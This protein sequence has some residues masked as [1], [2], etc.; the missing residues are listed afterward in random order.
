MSIDNLLS[1]SPDQAS[2]DLANQD[3]QDNQSNQNQI[4]DEEKDALLFIQKQIELEDQNIR[5]LKTR[6]WRR[7]DLY[8]NNIV[9]LFWDSGVGDWRIPDWDNLDSSN[10]EIAPRTIAIYRAHA[11]TVIAALSVQTPKVF[12]FPDD[13]DNPDDIE[14]AD[15]CNVIASVIEK[16]NNGPMLAMKILQILF[17]QG[18][19]FCYNYVKKDMAYGYHHSPIFADVDVPSFN[20]TCPI[21]GYDF[22]EFPQEITDPQQCFECSNIVTPVNEQ[23][24]YKITLQT[25]NEKLPKH[26]VLLDVSGPL[27]TKVSFYAKSQKQCGYLTFKFDENVAFLRDTFGQPLPD[28]TPSLLAPNDIRPNVQDS[29]Y[30]DYVRFS[31]DYFGS[32]PMNTAVVKC[33][34]LMPWMFESLDDSKRDTINLLKNRFKEGAYLIF[35]NDQLAEYCDE[36]LQ[37]HWTISENPLSNFVHGEPLGTNLAMAQDIRA[38]ACEL[39]LQIMEHSITETFVDATTIDRDKYEQTQASPGFMTPVK[40][41]AGENLSSSFFETRAANLTDEVNAVVTGTDQDAQ[42]TTGSLPSVYGGD[43]NPGGLTPV[44]ATQYSTSRTQALKRLGIVWQILCNFWCEIMK[45]SVSE[46]IDNMID[47][48]KMVTKEG[49]NFKNVLIKKSSL[50]GKI[51]SVETDSSDHLPMSWEDK[52]EVIVSLLQMKDPT[53]MQ[54][55][56]HPENAEL[57]KEIIALPEMYIPGDLDRTR[58]YREAIILMSSEPIGTADPIT[59]DMNYE[60]SLQT[61]ATDD[62]QVHMLICKEILQSPRGWELKQQEIQARKPSGFTNLMLHYHLHEQNLMQKTLQA[63]ANT[64]PGQ[65]PHTAAP[66]Q[67]Q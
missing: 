7:L 65:Q 35:I 27:N 20:T 60:S 34:W 26:R 14:T 10:N 16:H 8:F 38:E 39:R 12:F 36:S 58:Q 17:N 4:T 18:T 13:A 6:Q 3:N 9:N 28:G 66:S 50:R 49:G 48:E 57:M 42:F 64:A 56:L 59:G 43:D 22:G 61:E 11:E 41:N 62:D 21:C 55:L 40:R 47:D 29:P 31:P 53:I 45:K 19:A 24:D 63:S 15:T 51:G 37:D 5:L 33:T 2:P 52:K 25:G 46:F 23:V 32:Q 30:D 67:M 1:D 54:V 44:T